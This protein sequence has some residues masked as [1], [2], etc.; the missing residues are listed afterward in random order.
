MNQLT[1]TSP[2]TTGE[3]KVPEGLLTGP[4]WMA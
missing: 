4:L 3:G 1:L 2:Q